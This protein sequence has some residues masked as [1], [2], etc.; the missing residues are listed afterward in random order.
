MDKESLREQV[1]RLLAAKK[2]IE[3]ENLL[4]A[5]QDIAKSDR[6][7]LKIYFLLP[8]CS[9]EREA[10]QKTLFSKVSGLE[11]L[12]ERETRVKFYLRRIAFDVMDDEEVFFRYCKKN[13]VSLSELLIIAFC[14]AVY[15]EKVQAY[16]QKKAA[17]G[18]L[19]V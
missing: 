13:R 17:E 12:L 7:L 8:V 1:D 14:S 5:N 18:K 2:H 11:E 19:K 6:D 10:G 15:R 16:L 3:A 4:M 9:A